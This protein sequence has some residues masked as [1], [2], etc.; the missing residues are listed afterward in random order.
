MAEM[1]ST[2]P[3]SPTVSATIRVVVLNMEN[4]GACTKER[5]QGSTPACE[6]RE[7][8]GGGGRGQSLLRLG[9]VLVVMKE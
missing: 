2:P 1:T 5:K 7:R 4:N 8:E 3:H 9:G 6:K